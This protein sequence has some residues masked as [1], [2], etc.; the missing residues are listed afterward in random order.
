MREKSVKEDSHNWPGESKSI[1][2]NHVG[3]MEI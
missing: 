1:N 3:C 2:W